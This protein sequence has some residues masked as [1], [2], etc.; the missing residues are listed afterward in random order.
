MALEILP[1]LFSATDAININTRHGAVLAIGEIALALKNL[2]LEHATPNK[3][4]SNVI[5][6]DLNNLVAKFQERDQFRGAFS[7]QFIY[8][9]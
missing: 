3:Y 2:E 5:V 6:N 4:L 7:K 8:K 1:K 9:F